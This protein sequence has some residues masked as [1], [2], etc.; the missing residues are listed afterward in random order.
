MKSEQ[1]FSQSLHYKAGL[2]WWA[3]FLIDPQRLQKR[4]PAVYQIDLT[5][6]CNLKC[7]WCEFTGIH[8]GPDMSLELFENTYDEALQQ[9]CGI[10]LSG[11][12]EPTLWKEWD[13][14]IALLTWELA[15]PNRQLL[16]IGLI[17][18]GTLLPEL[19]AFATLLQ[20]R[21]VWMRLSINERDIEPIKPLLTL[22]PK[23]IGISLI[24]QTEDQRVKCQANY[25]KLMAWNTAKYV[26]MSEAMAD[27]FT[28][29]Y[30]TQCQ[31]HH[32]NRIIEPTGIRAFCC[33][34]RH[35]NGRPPRLC[36]VDC[37]YYHI[38]YDEIWEMN[39][40]T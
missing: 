2:P 33:H 36:P 13:K 14:L 25:D 7:S 30:Y 35:N 1:I 8:G 16:G 4:I 32:F 19:K 39:P 10:E 28:E 12:G 6:R 3:K 37:K 24:Y 21:N 23:Q 26:R 29:N 27:K 31:G 22:Y 20:Y 17:S 9:G 11:G 38:N 18:N 34:A 40:F 15:K 5:H